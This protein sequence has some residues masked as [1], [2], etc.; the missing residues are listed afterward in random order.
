VLARIESLNPVVNAVVTSDFGAALEQAAAADQR[1]AAGHEV[2]P[3]HG[4][5]ITVK[6]AIET[7]GMKSTGGAPELANHVPATD[8]PVVA[9]VRL[10]GAIVI[11]KTNL[12]LWS[13]DIQA[14]NELFG[15]T[16]NP[17]DATRVPGG[18]SGGAA[19]AVATGMSSFEI[20]TDIGGSVRFPAAFNGVFG[21]KPSY[22]IIPTTGY[23]DHPGGG[24]IQAD[25]NVF[26]PFA[27]SAEDLD[28]LLSLLVDAPA[29]F[30]VDLGEPP[31]DVKSLRIAAW[32]DDEFCPVDHQV[33]EVL[34]RTVDAMSAAGF[35]IDTTARPNVDPAEAAEL[36]MFL[37]GSAID[38]DGRTPD[39]DHSAWLRRHTRRE[40]IRRDWADFFD[41]YDVMLMPVSF[42]PPFEHAQDGTFR[43]RTLE[44]NGVE[45][46][47]SDVIRW[48]LLTGMAYLPATVPPIGQTTNGLPISMQVVGPYGSDRR[49]IALAGAVSELMGGW[50]APPLATGD[51]SRCSA[52][53]VAELR[54]SGK[55]L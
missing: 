8:A 20:G 25:V 49:T 53:Q 50:Q 41:S 51:D 36:G 14:F 44:C 52:A 6:D 1:L 19:A 26:G 32:L 45:R 15:T 47:Y 22:G 29:P 18:S 13:G 10:A 24:G 2:G 7:A 30:S 4:V 43:T 39:N 11:G 33:S 5:P 40:E 48:T 46:A 23:L 34:Q 31:A 17:W 9:A 38:Y 28:L 42:V 16:V 54:S 3:L 37:V 35:D 21:H 12:P 27:R 55:I